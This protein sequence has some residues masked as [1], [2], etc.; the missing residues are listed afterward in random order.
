MS[1]PSP[2]RYPVLDSISPIVTMGFKMRI[3]Q[4]RVDSATRMANYTPTWEPG[5]SPTHF[6]PA[7]SHPFFNFLIFFLVGHLEPLE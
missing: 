6:G 4:F 2:V 1:S 7:I 3:K 5:T